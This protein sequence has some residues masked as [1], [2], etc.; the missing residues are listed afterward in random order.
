MF[1]GTAGV[2]YDPNYHQVGDTIGNV[3]RR[4]LTANLA[5]IKH[6]VFMYARSTQSVN[7]DD[8]GH[9]PPPPAA[10]SAHRYDVHRH[11]A[12]R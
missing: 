10:R 6:S 11:A 7:G 9:E 12:V 5:A 4:A 1:G 2:A 3:S 8:T